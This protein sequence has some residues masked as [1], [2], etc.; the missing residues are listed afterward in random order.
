MNRDEKARLLGNII[1]A[2][3]F[4]GEVLLIKT[5]HDHD[6]RIKTLE[7]A[8]T[9]IILDGPEGLFQEEPPQEE[10]YILINAGKTIKENAELVEDVLCTMLDRIHKDGSS[11]IQKIRFVDMDHDR[12]IM[13]VACVPCD[14]GSITTDL[15]ITACNG[16][17]PAFI[18]GA[19]TVERKPQAKLAAASIAGKA[20]EMTMK[21]RVC[22]EE[23]I[24]SQ[25]S[26]S[27]YIPEVLNI[28]RT[29]QLN[30]EEGTKKYSLVNYYGELPIK[31]VIEHRKGNAHEK[32]DHEY[33][34]VTVKGEW[35]N[36]YMQSRSIRYDDLSG[37]V[38][39]NQVAD[40]LHAMRERY[41][42]SISI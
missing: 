1:T 27:G 33:L 28:L 41:L 29:E 39:I 2:L 37:S 26:K 10:S 42:N 17:E 23:A 11:D 19:E 34:D 40:E 12:H 31:L 16:M 4:A 22:N 30:G 7:D 25:D 14:D 3:S 6:R 5:L 15:M 24:W 38:I 36:L 20:C 18:D 21:A 13:T 35:N 9:E 8:L 32:K